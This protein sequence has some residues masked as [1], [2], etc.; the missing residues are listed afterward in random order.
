MAGTL[1]PVAG[2]G[3]MPPGG[4]LEEGLHF[5]S[6]HLLTPE[7]ERS[8]HYFF[9]NARNFWSRTTATTTPSSP[10]SAVPSEKRTGPSSK[11]SSVLQWTQMTGSGSPTSPSGTA[12]RRGLDGCW[13]D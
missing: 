9:A 12:R 3:I 5:P 2:P 13:T 11:P 7:T 10:S 8:T 4:V 1:A 6:A